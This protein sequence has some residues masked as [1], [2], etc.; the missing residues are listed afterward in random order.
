MFEDELQNNKMQI[1]GK[2]AATIVH[3]IRNPLSAIKLNLD[4]IKLS[5]GELPA[6]I[7]QSVNSCLEAVYRM[8]R[9]IENL[10]G[11]S[12]KSINCDEK[13]SLNSVADIAVS[14]M[15]NNARLCGVKI[16]KFLDPE[17]G[18]LVFDKNKMLQVA[19]NLITNAIEASGPEGVIKV[20]SYREMNGSEPRYTLEVEDNG[21]GIK[22][23][24]KKKIF[25]DF[26]TGK[27]N[28][29]GLGL[30]V[31]KAILGEYG[32][33]IDFESSYGVGTRFFV[34]FN[35]PIVENK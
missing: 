30:S 33:S 24:D 1:M 8:Q 15:Q 35:I 29:T 25:G 28:G 11:F 14:I 9:L 4:F 5:S 2:L 34:R 3:E 18:D 21:S 13:N 7:D 10:L 32:A 27:K 17:L 31:C 12:R 26:F 23:E 22:E 6:E 16:E 20:K 19:L